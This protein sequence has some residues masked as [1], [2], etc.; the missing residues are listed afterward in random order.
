MRKL[1]DTDLKRLLGALKKNSRL[2]MAGLRTHYRGR[3]DARSSDE[4]NY[5]A[6]IG[7]ERGQIVGAY[8]NND[9]IVY[10][11]IRGT[12]FKRHERR[13]AFFKPEDLATEFDLRTSTTIFT[14]VNEHGLPR[15]IR[16]SSCSPRYAGWISG[17]QAAKWCASNYD[18]PHIHTVHK[19]PDFAARFAITITPK[20]TPNEAT[21]RSRARRERVVR[22]RADKARPLPISEPKEPAVKPPVELSHPI[23]LRVEMPRRR[24]RR[25]SSSVTSRGRRSR[26]SGTTSKL[27]TR[28]P[29]SFRRRWRSSSLSM[30]CLRS[31]TTTTS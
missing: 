19:F 24:L 4:A 17:V 10:L 27:P 28:R 25:S 15:Y 18:N 30:E 21:R 31:S 16:G 2:T 12:T 8:N 5:L 7:I 29:L 9:Q 11:A 1:N 20:M 23:E 22:K 26:P 6:S 3:K 14:W 13:D